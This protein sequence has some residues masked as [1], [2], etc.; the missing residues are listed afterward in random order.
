MDGS[1]K[2]NNINTNIFSQGFGHSDANPFNAHLTSSNVNVEQKTIKNRRLNGY[3]STILNKTAF[4]E[5]ESK[6]L[7]LD[8]QI[9]E[10]EA[11]IKD[12][13]AK[14][15][16]AD[17]YGSVNE[18][19]GLKAK[20]NR[21]MQELGTL[22][23]QELYGGR[24]L[25]E[26]FSHERFKTKM[27]VIFKI[28]DFISRQILARLSKKVHSIIT[29]TDSLEKLSDINKSVNELIDMNVPYGEKIQNYEKLTEYLN[30]ASVIHSKISKSLGKRI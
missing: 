3:D 22:K 28:Q 19:L 14:I 11:I 13:D 21:I 26:E 18:A 23:K 5:S 15:K 7:S 27:P 24:V 30:Q 2:N 20:R 10:K 6:G 9:K 12:L 25:G 8:Y 17:N 29:L 16:S 1:G 4:D